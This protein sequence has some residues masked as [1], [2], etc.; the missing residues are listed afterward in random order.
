M[1]QEAD[2]PRDYPTELL[3]SKDYKI[4]SKQN[5]VKARCAGLVTNN[6]NYTRR[7]DL[8]GEDNCLLILD[9]I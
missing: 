8:E 9:V 5:T 2:I 4:E 3:S 6:I 1:F 7:F